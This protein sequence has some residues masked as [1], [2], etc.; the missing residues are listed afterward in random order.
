MFSALL[1]GLSTKAMSLTETDG[2][3][4]QVDPNNSAQELETIDI[5]GQYPLAYFRRN[6]VRK[7]NAFFALMNTLVDDK[8]YKVTCE[9]KRIQ[10]FSRLKERECEAHFVSRIIDEYTQSNFDF[11]SQ[12]SMQMRAEQHAIMALGNPATVKRKI[13]QKRKKQLKVMV[14]LINE[15]KE[16]L[17]AFNELEIAKY[18]L[19]LAK[20]KR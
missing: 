19:Q 5:V 8:D 18:Q 11:M 10:A 1:L 17:K 20:Q 9:K 3:S 2:L 16:L 6:L 13:E 14:D 4:Q 12:S 15:N 7:E